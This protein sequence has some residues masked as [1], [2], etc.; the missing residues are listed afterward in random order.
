MHKDAR[1]LAPVMRLGLYKY[2]KQRNGPVGN[3][4]PQFN[5]LSQIDEEILVAKLQAARKAISH[6]GEKGRTL[7]KEVS[8]IL[9]SF[10][11]SVIGDIL[12]CPCQEEK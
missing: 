11:P 7:E 5:S 4:P 12:Y 3:P 2:F 1:K 9:R 8:S 10:L 6:A